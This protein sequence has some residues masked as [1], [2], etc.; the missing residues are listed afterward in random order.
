MRLTVSALLFCAACASAQTFTFGVK[1]GG[2][3]TNPSDRADQSRKY[4]VGPAVEVGFANRFGI[5]A[6]ALYSRFGTSASGFAI[7][8]NTW[9]FPVLGKYYFA[10]KS[11]AVRPF[12]SAGAAFRNIWFDSAS[13]RGRTGQDR[14]IDSTEPATGAV[15]GGGAAFQLWRLKLAPEVRYTRWGG[16]NYPATNSNQAQLLLGIHF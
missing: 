3:L 5:E 4:I 1:G 15:V 9:E 14:R 13:R 10:T 8:G 11:S 6:D 16:L 2:F 12:A 7:R